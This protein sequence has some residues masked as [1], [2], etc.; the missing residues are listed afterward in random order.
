MFKKLPLLLSVAFTAMFTLSEMKAQNIF[1]EDFNGGAATLTNWTIIDGDSLNPNYAFMTDAWVS[2]ENPDNTGVGDSVMASTSWYIPAG[3]SDDYL[4]SPSITIGDSA[5]LTFDAKATDAGFPDGYE[6]LVS[7][8]TPTDTGLNANAPL[9]TVSAENASWTKRRIDLSA[10][11][12]QSIYLGIRNNSNDMNLLLVDNFSVDSLVAGVD[13]E[14]FAGLGPIGEYYRIPESQ[15]DDTLNFIA[16]ATNIGADTAYNVKAIFNVFRDGVSVLNDSTVPVPSI[17]PGD[18][19]LLISNIALPLVQSG[20]YTVQYVVASDDLDIDLTNDTVTTETL[21]VSDSTYARDNGQVNSSIGIG[22]GTSGELGHTYFL[23]NADTLT[24]VG[25]FIINNNGSMTGQPLSVNIRNFN[26]IPGSVI[27]SSDTVTFNSSGSAFVNLSF[28]NNGGYVALP[29][30]TFLVSVV[31]GDSNITLG[32]TARRFTP[33]A[34]WID[35]VG[36]PANGWATIESFNMQFTMVIR[37]NFGIPN[38]LTSLGENEPTISKLNVY[39]NPSNGVFEV[40]VASENINQ[41]VE[42]T[43]FDISGREVMSGVY[44]AETLLQENIDLSSFGKGV[45]FLQIKSEGVS[46]TRKLIVK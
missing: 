41:D 29:A 40:M 28:N 8:T 36:S 3:Q 38:V 35:F 2:F 14:L 42:M 16:A 20:A 15:I 46:E 24:S 26:G 25:V 5:V 39:P 23:S 34:G 44:R 9:L 18:T 7:T 10:Y 45:Y 19:S 21:V 13:L 32:T 30:D 22:A 6:V 33:G 4:I 43:V 12:G 17:N 37:P 31:E 1:F 27:A 11:I